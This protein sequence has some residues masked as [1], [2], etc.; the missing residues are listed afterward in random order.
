M[1]TTS[2]LS[3]HTASTPPTWPLFWGSER[4]HVSSL[5]TCELALAARV[6]RSQ[7]IE[8]VRRAARRQWWVDRGCGMRLVR[9]GLWAKTLGDATEDR[10]CLQEAG[11]RAALVL[12]CLLLHELQSFGNLVGR[13]KLDDI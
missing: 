4:G 6:A 2:P 3:T 11:R 7:G 10:G 5:E 9:R 13:G 8:V 1:A 12:P